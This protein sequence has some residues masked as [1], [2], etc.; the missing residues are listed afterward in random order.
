MLLVCHHPALEGSP[1]TGDFGSARLHK[2]QCLRDINGLSRHFGLLGAAT[3]P[4]SSLL[5]QDSGVG[6]DLADASSQLFGL[7][8]DRRKLAADDLVV[9]QHPRI[10]ELIIPAQLAFKEVIVQRV[11]QGHPVRETLC[12][13]IQEFLQVERD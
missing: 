3:G 2:L 5:F 11:V 1:L 9:K 6:L 4:L 8:L 7:V 13:T 10:V 12:G